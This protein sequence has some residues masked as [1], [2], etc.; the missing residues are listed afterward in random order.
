MAKSTIKIG[1]TLSIENVART[2]D[3][4]VSISIPKQ[5]ERRIARSNAVLREHADKETIYG[6]NTGFGPMARVYIGKKK[7]Q[8]LQYNLIRSHAA[9]QGKPID[10]GYVRAMMLVRLHTL[11]L[12]YSGVSMNVIST[13]KR[14]IEKD[15]VPIVPEHGSVGASGDLVQL[16]HIALGLIG[17]GEM[18]AKG[19]RM[20]AQSALKKYKIRPAT[21]TGR[22]GLA[23]I[24]GTTAM[25]AIAAVNIHKS[26]RLLSLAISASALLL[27]IVEADLESVHSIVGSVRPHEGQI[28]VAARIRRLLRGSRLAGSHKNRKA[29]RTHTGDTFETSEMVQEIYSI[30][31]VPQV[32]G[33]IL[34]T[35]SEARKVVEVELSAVTDNPIISK[36]YGVTHAGNFHGDYVALEMDKLRIAITKLSL[37]LERQINF[38]CN[39]RVNQKLPPFVNLG[40]VGLNLGLQGLQFVATSTAAE[41][42]TLA[43]PMST[44]TITTN[45]DNQDIV[46]MG[47]N[48]SLLTERVVENTYQITSILFAALLQAVDHIGKE[49]KMSKKTRDIYTTL[50]HTFP[51]FTKDGD[52][53]RRVERLRHTLEKLNLPY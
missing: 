37:L 47:T 43:H 4:P 33:P 51:R 52:I 53:A 9:G 16:A 30:R 1:S 17:E 31:C 44:H 45:N 24:N 28:E 27:E 15:I 32:I 41:N 5:V 18:I 19:K 2:A 13:L 39:D 29:L 12:G 10:V 11:S 14:C 48:A 35:L 46:S 34:D 22:D 21:L 25:S 6:V 7:Q 50:R 36:E 38:L 20:S 23:L 3:G 40:T 42:Q 26:E 49:E 8:E